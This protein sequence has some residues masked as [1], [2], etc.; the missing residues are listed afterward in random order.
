[1]QERIG[2]VS[3]RPVRHER[4]GAQATPIPSSRVLEGEALPQVQDI[5]TRVLE[6]F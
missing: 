4:I 3:D 1:M 2:P 5:V 6:C